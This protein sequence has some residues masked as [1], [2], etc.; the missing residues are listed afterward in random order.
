MAVKK[1]EQPY[2]ANMKLQT[3]HVP[4]DSFDLL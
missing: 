3:S 2:L 4:L 1:S